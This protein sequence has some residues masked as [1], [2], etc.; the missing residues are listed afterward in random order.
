MI[1]EAERVNPSPGLFR[2]QRVGR[3]WPAR[4]AERASGRDFEE[5]TRWERNTLRPNYQ[6]PLGARMTFYH[7]TIEPLDYGLFF[8][9]WSLTPEE[10][11]LRKHG[12][13]PGQKV[14]Y[15][16]RR[17]F[18]LWNT[19]YFI[20]PGRL[21]WDSPPRGYASLIPHSTFIYP[22]PGS[23]DGPD[24]QARRAS[25][26]ATDDFRILRNDQAFPRAWVVHRA[27]VVPPI[28][29][30]RLADRGKIMQ[31]LLYQGDEFWKLAGVPVRDPHSVAWVETDR[32]REV[33]RFL[34]RAAPDPAEVVTVTRDEPQRVELTA[35]LR[36]AGLVVVSDLYYPGW[37]LTVDGRPG[38]ILR[39]NRAM[40]GVTLP[41]GTHEL[42]FRYDPLS[43]RLGILLSLL[44]L[45]ATVGLGFWMTNDR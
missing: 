36:S 11:T 19:R 30:L 15:Y 14:W 20:V 28:R 31:E 3:W 44:G 16:P 38:E 26:G 42:V 25:W 8:L 18:D 12:L 27:Y 40:R 39:A 34:S 13:K 21:V 37:T 32:P 5:I 1:R 9:P 7:D 23:F 41:A 2:I 33:E 35:V 6:L 10:A 29:G 45:I 22:A 24:G 43:F 4:W 17:G